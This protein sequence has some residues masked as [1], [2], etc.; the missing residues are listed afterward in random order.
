MLRT[1][2]LSIVVL[3]A[4]MTVLSGCTPSWYATWA[5]RDAYGAISEGQASALGKG[6]KFDIAYNPVDCDRYLKRAKDETDSDVD[7]L[8][9][10]GA[11]QVAFKNSRAFQTSKETLYSSALAL[12]NASRGWETVLPVG[13]I[14]STAEKIRTRKGAPEGGTDSTNRYIN[15][16]GTYSLTRRLVGGGLL[17]LGA[18]MNL[19]ANV[20]GDSDTQVGSLVEGSFTQPLLRG[21]WRGLAFEDQHRLVRDF[22]IDVYE[23]DRFRQTF[24]VDI[25]Q[26]YY[27]VLTLKDQLENS[28]TNVKR[29][30][31]AYLVTKSMVGGDKKVTPAHEAQAEQDLLTAQIALERT[32]LAYSN[33][34]DNFKITLGLPISKDLK[35]DY[36]G[37]LKR[38]NDKGPQPLTFAE[39]A[40]ITTSSRTDTALLR[41]RAS[42]RDGDKDVEIAADNFNPQLD[43]ELKASAPGTER[44]RP[45][46]T[47]TKHH[48]RS[49]KLTLNYGLD[50]TANRDAYRNAMIARDQAKRSLA[51]AEDT[52]TLN[53]RNSFRSLKQSGR[54][55]NLQAKS[56]ELAKR[57]T[58][59]VAI[60]RK[61][62]LAT[63]RDVLEAEAA[64]N[65]SLNG[66]TT[67][68][69]NYTI[70][71]LQFLASLGM[72]GV[73][74]DGK[75]SE[76]KTSFG[77]DRLQKRYLYLKSGKDDKKPKAAAAQKEAPKENQN[78]EKADEK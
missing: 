48:T 71:R 12:A 76:R 67:S 13:E 6:Y 42:R 65:T 24:A 73:D 52:A 57:R 21:A 49:V 69:V 58:A 7:V 75:L 62:G 38:L 25:M 8:S 78:K 30:Q 23:F 31:T 55:F 18:T 28:R 20:L 66:L 35:L 5:D 14:D 37:A 16:D 3:M 11:L 10:E 39:L 50:Q 44:A 2:G 26:K 36:P 72:L 33:A 46:R 41:A 45:Q 70:T 74:A 1:T 63:T 19:V 59:L 68:L 34:L 53:V 29:L 43:L 40:A 17:T 77:Y 64:L 60:Q 51:V 61:Q 27:A 56:V 32:I 47:Q 15:A 4:S 54:S 22:L 9:L